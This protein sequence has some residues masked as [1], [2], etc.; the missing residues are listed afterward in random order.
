MPLQFRPT[1]TRSA[2]RAV[3]V[4][5]CATGF[6]RGAEPSRRAIETIATVRADIKRNH[7]AFRAG[8][9]AVV[10]RSIVDLSRGLAIPPDM[11]EQIRLQHIWAIEREK[12]T[13]PAPARP[14]HGSSTDPRFDW[15]DS[16]HVT[17]VR[18]QGCCNSCSGFSALGAYEGS[19]LIRNPSSRPETV[20]ASEQYVINCGGGCTCECAGVPIA[21]MRFMVIHGTAS[22]AAVP[23]QGVDQ[24]CDY[25]VPVTYKAMNADYVPAPTTSYI[26]AISD[27][28]KALIA[29]GPLS[30]CVC[31]DAAFQVYAGG[32]FNHTAALDVNHA[33]TLVGW[34]DS[35][36]AWLIKNSWGTD[37]GEGGYMWIAY[38]SHSIGKYA[39]WCDATSGP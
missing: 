9:S 8:Y 36:N 35:K 25:M 16:D 26:P 27:T 14:R 37:W 6:C 32:V 29:H 21:V 11:Q 5:M 38:T 15:R 7:L 12:A 39:A 1:V 10:E 34:D 33:V 13:G 30:V 24:P 18:W 3:F 19:Y 4:V 17:L 23:Y 22:A 31:V 20:H 28:K 2:V